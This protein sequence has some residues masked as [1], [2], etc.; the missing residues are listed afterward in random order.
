MTGRVVCWMLVIAFS[1]ALGQLAFG[2][3]GPASGGEYVVGGDGTALGAQDSESRQV[4]LRRKFFLNERPRHAWLQVVGRDRLK[5]H[6]NGRLVGGASGSRGGAAVV[7]DI[8]R[9]L[10]RGPTV[11]AISASQESVSLPPL[12]AV[13]AGYVIGETVHHIESDQLWRCRERVE[14]RAGWW[15]EVDFD[16]RHWQPA[17]LTECVLRGR[18]DHPP[19]SV[20]SP[21]V[22]DWI[23]AA[24]F[25]TLGQTASPRL[26]VLRLLAAIGTGY[27]ANALRLWLDPP[28]AKF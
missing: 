2:V 9:H 25:D 18:V 16:D 8:T 7:A 17:R 26:V 10:Q 21:G 28:E 20:I 5:V 11:V 24:D 4:Y 12:A 13:K 6:V 23:T 22:G 14:R 27:L 1:A 3:F 15:F 19:G